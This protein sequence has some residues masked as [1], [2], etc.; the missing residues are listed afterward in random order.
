M[1][2][3]LQPLPPTIFAE[4]LKALEAEEKRISLSR[5]SHCIE[6]AQGRVLPFS[7]NLSTLS[8]VFSKG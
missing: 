6:K 3:G 7:R 5:G 4:L 8:A 1:N 2:K